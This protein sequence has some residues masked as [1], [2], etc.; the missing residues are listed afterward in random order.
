[1]ELRT[2]AL[3]LASAVVLIAVLNF[4]RQTVRKIA[5]RR[6]EQAVMEVEKWKFLHPHRGPL[7]HLPLAYHLNQAYRWHAWANRM[8]GYAAHDGEN[9]L[10]R[11]LMAPYDPDKKEGR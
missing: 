11:K 10:E 1:M 7:E 6:L 5:I 2:C 9:E 8:S 4:I 3:V